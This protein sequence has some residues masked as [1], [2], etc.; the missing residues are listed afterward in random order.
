MSASPQRAWKSVESPSCD[1]SAVSSPRETC[2]PCAFYEISMSQF[3]LYHEHEGHSLALDL[4]LTFVDCK[5]LVWKVKAGGN[6]WLSCIGSHAKST[7]TKG[8]ISPRPLLGDLKPV[9]VTSVLPSAACL[10]CKV[11]LVWIKWDTL[12]R[13]EDGNDKNPVPIFLDGHHTGPAGE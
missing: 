3:L 11:V 12:K 5:L 7:C 10:L 13:H 8:E 1:P 4:I 6:S 2:L 9:H